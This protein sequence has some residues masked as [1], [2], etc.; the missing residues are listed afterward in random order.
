MT[1]LPDTLLR[2]VHCSKTLWKI[3]PVPGLLPDHSLHPQPDFHSSA[4]KSDFS[5]LHFRISHPHPFL[6]KFMTSVHNL[7][8][9]CNIHTVCSALQLFPVFHAF[10]IDGRHFFINGLSLKTER[11]VPAFL[12]LFDRFFFLER[13]SLEIIWCALIYI[14]VQPIRIQVVCVCSP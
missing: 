14:I 2:K 3:H 7:L 4:R 10:I 6:Y 13:R 8:F 12:T 5:F 9:F 1:L 11:F